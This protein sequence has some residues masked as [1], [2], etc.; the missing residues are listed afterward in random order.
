MLRKV[1]SHAVRGRPQVGRYAP[2]NWNIG[3]EF[4]IHD[5]E[6]PIHP[7][8]LYVI[9]TGKEL[10]GE[11]VERR[12]GDFCVDSL[13]RVRPDKFVGLRKASCKIV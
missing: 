9:G 7:V 11:L 12:V 8:T 13:C 5:Q 4:R 6:I 2:G 1:P 10:I 3:I